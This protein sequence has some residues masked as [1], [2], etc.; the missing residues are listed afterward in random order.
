MPAAH[1]ARVQLA[2]LLLCRFR[3]AAD[4][5]VCTVTA[6]T[7]TPRAGR[8]SVA[9]RGGFFAR[10]LPAW[11]RVRAPGL[12]LPLV[13]ESKAGTTAGAVGCSPA[14]PAPRPSPRVP[15]P[16][17]LGTVPS[18]CVCSEVLYSAVQ[19]EQNYF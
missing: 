4:K 6:G 10:H 18:R 13:C 5:H 15:A 2:T 1:G 3:P 19:R 14:S 7:T 9:F 16:R 11:P 8:A 12:D 17:L